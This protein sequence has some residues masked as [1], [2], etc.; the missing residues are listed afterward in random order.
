MDVYHGSY[1]SFNS[2]HIN[3]AEPWMDLNVAVFDETHAHQPQAHSS[4]LTNH[5]NGNSRAVNRRNSD[6]V[7]VPE[8]S[9]GKRA[10][11]VAK[12]CV[13]PRSPPAATVET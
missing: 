6:P 1:F 7:T 13:S 8:G 10:R 3:V 2:L 9:T 5:Q 4:H 11:T 12:T